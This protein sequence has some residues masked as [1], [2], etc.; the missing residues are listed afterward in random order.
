MITELVIMPCPLYEIRETLT[1]EG[2]FDA[3]KVKCRGEAVN[4]TLDTAS[5][6]GVSFQSEG[7]A[8]LSVCK[9]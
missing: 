1:S 4:E 3:L 6:D 5:M 2:S 7:S 8:S 9:D